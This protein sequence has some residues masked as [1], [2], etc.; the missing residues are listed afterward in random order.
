MPYHKEQRG[1]LAKH[2][3]D[4]GQRDQETFRPD[5]V[6]YS[7]DDRVKLS[8]HPDGFVQFSGERQGKI[9]SGRNEA[10]EPNGLGLT[11]QPLTDPIT[12]G[13]TFALEVWGLSDFLELESR[14]R[15][16]AVI[17]S[18]ESLYY[19]KTTP[20]D[21]AGVYVVEGFVFPLIYWQAVRKRAEGYVLT[22]AHRE[23]GLPGALFEFQVIPLPGQPV[24]LGVIASRLGGQFSHA[25][26]G[27]TL[28]GPSEFRRADAL[29]A[30]YPSPWSRPPEDHLD[31]DP[32]PS[33]DVE[34]A[35]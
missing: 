17:F 19:R 12:T 3:V 30:I 23:F 10:G 16:N 25:P 7:A 32:I 4:Y 14:D 18:E 28:H 21:L 26:S 6:E 5:T 13:P 29:L 33:D 34:R 22:L 9:R 24:F 31:Y 15:R 20:E 8:I 1:Y 11:T 35:T 2:P 27:F